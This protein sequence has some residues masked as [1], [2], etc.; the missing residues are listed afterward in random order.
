MRGKVEE[1]L[2]NTFTYSALVE[3][4]LDQSM[5]NIETFPLKFWSREKQQSSIIIWMEGAIWFGLVKLTYFHHCLE[6]NAGALD[7]KDQET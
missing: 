5:R 4:L 7:Q 1:A 2:M 3:R 6:T